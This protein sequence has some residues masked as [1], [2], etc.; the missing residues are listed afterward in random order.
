MTRDVSCV[1]WSR[2]R[3]QR[4]CCAI[5]TTHGNWYYTPISKINL[6]N[7]SIMLTSRS[8]SKSSISLVLTF[9]VIIIKTCLEGELERIVSDNEVQPRIEPC[10][11]P[12]VLPCDFK[13][14]KYCLLTSDQRARKVM[15][16]YKVF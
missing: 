9:L 13:S 1:C 6:D 4:Q 15:Q 16:I 14:A 3:G 7:N 5:N 12:H 8:S 2:L 10:P 11:P